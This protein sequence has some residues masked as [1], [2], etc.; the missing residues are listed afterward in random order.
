MNDCRLVF[1]KSNH[2]LCLWYI[3]NNVLINC[4]KKFIIKETWEKFFNEWKTMIYAAFEFDY[5]DLW[6]KF[7]NCYNLFHDECIN[8]LYEIYIRDYRRRFIKCYI[9]QILHSDITMTSRDKNAHAVL[10]R[11]LEKSIDDLKTVVNDIN[12][13]LI[14]ERQNHRINL[15]E[16]RIRYSMKLRKSIFQ[17]LTSFVINVALRKMNSQYQMLIKRSIVMFCCTNVFIII[18]E[19]S[20]NHRIQKRL[21]QEESILFENVHSHWR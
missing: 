18:I 9:N 13:M 12:L 19:L 4:K 21:Y 5:R 10:K 17:Q 3:N 8:Y 14:N 15:D 2:L 1:L 16:N 6:D 20:C 7:V 11:Q